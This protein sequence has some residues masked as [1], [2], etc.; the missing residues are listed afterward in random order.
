MKRPEIVPYIEAKANTGD[1]AVAGTYHTDILTWSEQ[2]AGLLRRVGAG[3]PINDQV[4]WDHVV[5]EIEALGQYQVDQVRSWL[6]QAMLHMLKVKA[7]PNSLAVDHWKAEM[8]GFLDDAV[9][10]Y[11]PSMRLRIDVPWLYLRAVRR[12]PLTIDGV[13]ALPVERTCPP[14]IT[15]DYLLALPRSLLEEK[16]QK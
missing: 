11:R 5:E 9:D 13:K 10:T 3:E 14:E 4:D 12:L 8:R 1:S 15:L 7:F 6:M 2:Q 16:D